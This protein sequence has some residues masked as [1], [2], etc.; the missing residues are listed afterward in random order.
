[1]TAIIDIL[2][3]NDIYQFMAVKEALLINIKDIMDA[4]EYASKYAL[5]G[6]FYTSDQTISIVVGILA[7]KDMGMFIGGSLGAAKYGSSPS[8]KDYTYGI[9]ITGINDDEVKNISR[10]LYYEL[11]K[12]IPI[13]NSDNG[14]RIHSDL[15][16]Q[17]TH[18]AMTGEKRFW[19]SNIYATVGIIEQYYPNTSYTKVADA[20]NSRS[21]IAQTLAD[22]EIITDI[23][24]RELFVAYLRSLIVDTEYDGVLTILGQNSEAN[25][26]AETSIAVSLTNEHDEFNPYNGFLGASFNQDEFYYQHER[27]LDV[28]LEISMP[29][30]DALWM[31]AK[32]IYMCIRR[33]TPGLTSTGKVKIAR[34]P[35]HGGITPRDL[36]ARKLWTSKMVVPVRIKNVTTKATEIC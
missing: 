8:L 31:L 28:V 9:N 27:N 10:Y 3:E 18:T 12:R 11:S 7:D 21:G 4:T 22:R 29:D 35:V 1:M 25:A 20:S 15:Y 33:D 24:I 23:D 26:D 13:I 14:V 5:S 32:Y 36:G 19:L 16:M 34:P 17:P 30:N 2:K 6:S